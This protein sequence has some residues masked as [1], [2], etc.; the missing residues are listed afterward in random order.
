MVPRHKDSTVLLNQ[1]GMA[2]VKEDMVSNMVD[3]VNSRGNM[4]SLLQ[5]KVGTTNRAVMASNKE[6]MEDPHRDN[7][8]RADT[9]LSN[10][11]PMRLRR[12]HDI[13]KCW[14]LGL[15]RLF[16]AVT[17]DFHD[18]AMLMS[19]FHNPENNISW[20]LKRSKLSSKINE[21]LYLMV[22]SWQHTHAS[23]HLDIS[24][25]IYFV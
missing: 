23:T 6:D 2:R 25:L 5:A 8:L 12:L 17:L 24:H 21:G 18:W 22:C 16:K 4:V 13:R 9:H 1:W 3:L 10:L 19:S 7:Q 14:L 20:S 15:C 11:R